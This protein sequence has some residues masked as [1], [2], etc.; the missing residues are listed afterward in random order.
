MDEWCDQQDFVPDG[1]RIYRCSKCRK[2]LH[3][4][5]IFGSDG[6][7]AGWRLPPHKK[8]G[9]KIRAITPRIGSRPLSFL[10]YPKDAVFQRVHAFASH[11]LNSDHF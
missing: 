10:V 4:R 8:K 1:D 5:K 6:E 7:L 3:P 2:R 11:V 9:H